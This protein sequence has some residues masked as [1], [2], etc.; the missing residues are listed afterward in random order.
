MSEEE[1][2]DGS[3]ALAGLR[4]RSGR[5]GPLLGEQGVRDRLEELLDRDILACDVQVSTARYSRDV[6][7]PR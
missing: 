6:S 4:S 1:L 7:C 3:S 2:Q 5:V